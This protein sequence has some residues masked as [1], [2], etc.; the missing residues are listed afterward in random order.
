MKSSYSGVVLLVLILFASIVCT[1][2]TVNMYFA[3][4]YIHVLLFSGATVM[5]FPLAWIVYGKTI[6]DR[7]GGG[8]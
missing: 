2:Y 4:R 7:R 6:R 8:K 3:Q 1:Q 5:L